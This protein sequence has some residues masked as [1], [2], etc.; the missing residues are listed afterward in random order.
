[1]SANFTMLLNPFLMESL[2]VLASVLL[3]GGGESDDE[4]PVESAI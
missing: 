3:T 4:K 1:M 2:P